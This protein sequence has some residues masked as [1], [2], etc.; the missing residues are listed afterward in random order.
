MQRRSTTRLGVRLRAPSEG[1]WIAAVTGGVAVGSVVVS[2]EVL[3]D[4]TVSPVIGA[5]MLAG[6]GALALLVVR[7]VRCR[8]ELD[9]DRLTIANV[10]RTVTVA[11]SEVIGASLEHV[12][13]DASGNR[14]FLRLPGRWYF[15]VRIVT[16]AGPV[17]ATASRRRT[18]ASL[19]HDW[20]AFLDGL[21][22]AGM[23]D[24]RHRLEIVG[25]DGTTW[26]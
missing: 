22:E 26:P 14:F 3:F 4:P 18:P 1:T 16:E 6:S 19:R 9:G 5:V 24:L 15:A 11:D 12:Y 8:I 2:V 17:R 20:R 25:P 10:W 23:A 21:D 13:G 7:W